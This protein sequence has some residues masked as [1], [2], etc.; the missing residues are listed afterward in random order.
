[1]S[2]E[3]V[4][5]ETV[6]AGEMELQAAAQTCVLVTCKSAALQSLGLLCCDRRRDTKGTIHATRVLDGKL[7]VKPQSSLQAA[8]V[9]YIRLCNENGWHEVLETKWLPRAKRGSEVVTAQTGEPALCSCPSAG[10]GTQKG[11]EEMSGLWL[12]S[13]IVLNRQH[14]PHPIHPRFLFLWLQRQSVPFCVSHVVFIQLSY[15]DVF[16]S[17]LRKMLEAA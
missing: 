6:E 14:C 12:F 11:V 5:L 8:L 17:A 1:M 3:A 16:I 13:V 15:P 4:S 2:A 10:R 9:F 7:P